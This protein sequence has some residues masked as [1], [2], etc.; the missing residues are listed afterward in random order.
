MKTQMRKVVV[1]V[2]YEDLGEAALRSAFALASAAGGTEV[3]AVYVRSPLE[4]V[5]DQWAHLAH[6]TRNKL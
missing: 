6:S 3:H 1:G 5:S 4:G 2:D